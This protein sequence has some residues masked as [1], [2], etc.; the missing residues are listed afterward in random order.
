[1]S[2]FIFLNQ[3]IPPSIFL[4]RFQKI[5]PTSKTRNKQTKKWGTISLLT[6][7]ICRVIMILSIPVSETMGTGRPIWVQ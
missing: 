6:H 7:F 3:N 4:S 1:M 2:I 5:S